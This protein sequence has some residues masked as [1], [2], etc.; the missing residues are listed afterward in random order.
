MT[1][2]PNRTDDPAEGWPHAKLRLATAADVRAVAELHVLTGQISFQGLVPD[3]LLAL[4]TVEH[5]IDRWRERIQRPEP[6]A[7][8]WLATV[9]D[10]LVGLCYIHLSHDANVPPRT[11]EVQAL[12]V[13]PDYAGLGIGT[14]ML[15][16][17]LAS[18]RNAGC[19]TAKLY[20]LEANTAAQAF[21]RKQGWAPDGVVSEDPGP[22]GTV[23]RELRFARSLIDGN[24]SDAIRTG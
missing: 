22:D 10:D 11:G 24:P 19:T 9:R 23:I 12:Y 2:R 15:D 16:A 18:L 13:R 8:T 17:G 3:A 6:G 21:Y 7:A 5:R 1:E 4:A 20:V 14:K